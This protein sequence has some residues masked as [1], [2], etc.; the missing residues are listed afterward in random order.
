MLSKYFVIKTASESFKKNIEN[1]ISEL[2][3][4]KVL[5]YGAGKGFKALDNAYGLTEKL[6]IIAIADKKYEKED[7]KPYKNIKTINPQEIL[8]E[9]FDYIL[10][11]NENPSPIINFLTGEI[12]I[13]SEKV[14]S[15]FIEEVRDERVNL[16]Y[17]YQHK[18]DKTLPKLIKKLKNKKVVFY[19]A[20]AYLKLIQKYFDISKLN[21]IGIADKKYEIYKSEEEFLGYKTVAPSEIENLKPDYVIVATKFYITI[22]ENL[23]Y[24]TLHGSKIKIKPLVKKSLLT[25]IKEIWNS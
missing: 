17:L 12:N 4:K 3:N 20:G 21:V 14:K 13:P 7:K 19:G 1:L 11:S 5:I 25:L 16:N 8:N 15:L 2:L 22:I 10:V 6:N 9:N 23:H 24:D 18:F